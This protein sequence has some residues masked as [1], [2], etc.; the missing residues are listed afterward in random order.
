ME[1]LEKKILNKN[2]FS[3]EVETT[4]AQNPGIN[5]L[6]ALAI[7]TEKYDLEEEKV[8]RLLNSHLKDKIKYEA[9]ELNLVKGHNR[10]KLPL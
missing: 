4:Y 9:I 1:E 5:L 10:G 2:S 8:P 3:I 7:V 6:D